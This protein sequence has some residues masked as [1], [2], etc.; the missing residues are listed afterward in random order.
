[1][2]LI[3]LLC[4]AANWRYR[5]SRLD[6]IRTLCRLI[7]VAETEL[8][9]YETSAATDLGPVVD[10]YEHALLGVYPRARY[11]V[12]FDAKYI[13]NPI[14]LAPEWL[15]DWIL[16]RINDAPLPNAVKMKKI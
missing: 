9:A 5:S 1:M 4:I 8:S 13:Y 12:G 14:A 10:A 11:M 3:L 7:S 16:R 2:I 6:R 15:G